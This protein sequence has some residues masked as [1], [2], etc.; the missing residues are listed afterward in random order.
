MAKKLV[1]VWLREKDV[2]WLM[3]HGGLSLAM[4]RL[5]GAARLAEKESELERLREKQ[6]RFL[7]KH[8]NLGAAPD[9]QSRSDT[10]GDGPAGFGVA[11][12]TGD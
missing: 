11:A 1:R 7:R 4:G 6:S 12:P 9:G 5:V 2:D 3:R 10:A 8:G